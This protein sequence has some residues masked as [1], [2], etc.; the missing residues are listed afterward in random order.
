MNAALPQGLS[1]AAIVL[2]GTVAAAQEERYALSEDGRFGK[3]GQ[4]IEFYHRYG[5]ESYSVDLEFGVTDDGELT[6]DSTLDVKIRKTEGGR[7]SYRCRLSDGNTQATVKNISKTVT[8]ILFECKIRPGRFAKAAGV[9]ADQVADARLVYQVVMR[10]GVPS[11]GRWRGIYLLPVT[12]F[13][14]MEMNGYAS[15][16]GEKERLTVIFKSIPAR[17]ERDAPRDLTRAGFRD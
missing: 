15:R 6:S 3:T 5:W 14:A 16:R 9:D 11:A 4:P 2:L 12:R 1:F 7:W 8:T 10:D 13:E 17:G